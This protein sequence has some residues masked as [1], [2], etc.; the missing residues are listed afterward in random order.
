MKRRNSLILVCFVMF[1]FSIA[2]AGAV[3]IM[4]QVFILDERDFNHR[5]ASCFLCVQRSK[6]IEQINQLLG[7]PC[8]ELGP[9]DR[10]TLRS[11]GYRSKKDERLDDALV[12]V[13]GFTNGFHRFIFVKYQVNGSA[14]NIVNVA[15]GAM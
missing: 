4:I 11:L 7:A 10:G 13:Y 12:N 14:T 6:T 1:A 9:N 2:V 5:F 8:W 15:W 3:Y